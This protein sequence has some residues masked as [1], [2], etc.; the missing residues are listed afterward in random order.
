MHVSVKKLP[1]SQAELRI[2]LPWEEWCQDIERAIASLGKSVKVHGFRPGKAPRAVIEQRLGREAVL[3][4]AAEQ[5]VRRSYPQALAKEKVEAMGTPAV[6][7]GKVKDQEALEYT[8]ITAII[9]IVAL[10]PWKAVVQEINADFAK[11]EEIVTETEVNTVLEKLVAMRARLVPV[12]REARFGDSVRVDFSVLQDRVL[13]ENGKS[14][15][16]PIVLGTNAFIPGFEEA[17]VGM[18]AGECKT[19]ELVFPAAYHAVH[20]AGKP[21]TFDVRVRA[22]EERVLPALNDTFAR[23]VGEFASVEKLRENARA[24]LLAEKQHTAQEGHRT[25]ILDALVDRATLEYPRLLVEEELGRMLREFETQLKPMGIELASYLDRMKKTQTA[26][27][28]EWEPQAKKRIA[29]HLV[30]ETVAREEE[31]VVANEAVEVE[32]NKTL[33]RY[34]DVADI[35][36]KIDMER[37]YMASRGKLQNETVFN[38]LEKL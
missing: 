4:E 3:T 2:T 10:K 8:V 6:T 25:R 7:L 9:P 29:A 27:L 23:S 16:H 22:V 30:L 26:L 13:I 19:F 31:I 33:L 18:R 21:A 12:E 1:E 37:L 20:L 32:M 36:E 28:K 5:A 24:G 35:R 15:N 17:L 34:Q 38:F 14:E 11:H